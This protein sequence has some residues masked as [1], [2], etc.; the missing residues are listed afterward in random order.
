MKNKN[1]ALLTN[2]VLTPDHSAREHDVV[3]LLMRPH[4]LVQ[5]LTVAIQN[6]WI[7][8]WNCK[9]TKQKNRKKMKKT[10]LLFILFGRKNG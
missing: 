1:R 8:W 3:T 4:R 2:R 10:N 5:G 6:N 9:Q 7:V